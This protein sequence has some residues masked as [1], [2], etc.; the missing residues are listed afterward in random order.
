MPMLIYLTV[1]GFVSRRPDTRNH[2]L[3]T[4]IGRWLFSLSVEVR[5]SRPAGPVG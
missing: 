2:I 5:L 1:T 3:N 4:S